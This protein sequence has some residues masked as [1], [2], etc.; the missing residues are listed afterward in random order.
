MLAGG[1]V[2]S[3]SERQETKAIRELRKR[4]QR[5]ALEVRRLRKMLRQQERKAEE[6][7]DEVEDEVT[8]KFMDKYC[9][10][11]CK[12]C[13]PKCNS[14]ESCNTFELMGRQYYKCEKCGAKGRFSE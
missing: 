11:V 10:P 9:P 12:P 7:D 6:N 13:C 2:K 1:C 8:E 4:N 3:E 5:L 14:D